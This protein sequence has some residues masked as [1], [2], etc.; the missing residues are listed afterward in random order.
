MHF[1]RSKYDYRVQ[2]RSF[3]AR[4]SS[5]VSLKECGPQFLQAVTEAVGATE[6]ALYVAASP[7]GQYRCAASVGYRIP[8]SA[9]S[10]ESALVRCLRGER[11][12]LAPEGLH[13]GLEMRGDL[14]LDQYVAEVALIVPLI[15]QDTLTGLMFLGPERTGV[16]YGAEDLEFLT[17]VGEQVAGVLATAHLA[18]QVAQTREFDA[19]HRLTSFVIHDIKNSVASLSLL[20]RNALQNFDDPEFQ[21]DAIRTISGV[22]N[23]MTSLLGKL[24]APAR[25]ETVELEPVDLKA[26]A[27]DVV[28]VVRQATAVR[29]LKDAERV[30]VRGDVEAL[31]RVL[32]NLVTNA[33][34]A[35]HGDG[36]Q[37]SVTVKTYRDGDWAVME[38]DDTGV[39]MSDDYLRE[40]LFVPF[41][42]TKPGG[43]GVGLYQAREIVRRHGG[44]ITVTSR[45][46]EGTTFRVRLPLEPRPNIG[47][48]AKDHVIGTGGR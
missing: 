37:G 13:G 40:S 5:A 39:G 18:E 19:F 12:P 36:R 7:D 48:M 21:R 29:L 27:D 14:Q 44:S 4:L 3:T 24:E 11:R 6:G 23:R 38:V 31:R 46:G 45:R 26:V 9:I 28:R 10:A 8:V 17:T 42:S 16:E 20:S 35:V 43:W 33:V 2:W 25:S 15:W 22:V 1:Y 30:T 41:R 47:V 32:E 34:Q